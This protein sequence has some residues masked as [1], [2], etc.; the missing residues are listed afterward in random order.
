MNNISPTMAHSNFVARTHTSEQVTLHMKFKIVKIVHMFLFHEGALVVRHVWEL[1]SPA[2]LGVQVSDGRGEGCGGQ[3]VS[4]S[5]DILRSERGHFTHAHTH[6][7]HTDV[8]NLYC[9]S[10]LCANQVWI[11]V[12]GFYLFFFFIQCVFK[13]TRSPQRELPCF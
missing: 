11:G 9:I 5:H 7:A 8:S 3:V 6:S 12:N 4:Q 2:E 13:H 10:L 1:E